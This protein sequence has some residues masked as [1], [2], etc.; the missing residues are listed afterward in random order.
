M[1]IFKVMVALLFVLSTVVQTF[2]LTVKVDAPQVSGNQSGANAAA[3]VLENKIGDLIKNVNDKPKK[4]AKANAN[5]ASYANHVATQRGYTDYEY[6]AFTLGGMAGFQ[7]PSSSFSDIRGLGDN[8]REKGDVEVGASAQFALQLGLRAWPISD[9]LYLGAKIGM[10]KFKLE[11]NDKNDFKYNTFMIGLTGNYL[12]LDNTSIGFG[13]VRW[14]GV[15]FGTGLIYQV[16]DTKYTMGLDSVSSGGPIDL[17]V[18]PRLKYSMDSKNI[19]IPLELTTALRLLYCINLTVGIGADFAFGKTDVKLGME[20]DIGVTGD[21]VTKPGRLQVEGGT[22][23]NPGV[24]KPKF[25]GGIGIGVSDVIIIDVPF[26]LYV[27]S[28]FD[29]GITLGTVW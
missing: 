7:L 5:S 29:V 25:M 18:D 12:L 24:I 28:G 9:N 13:F 23:A 10:M 1:K 3:G 14:R 16:S 11:P 4:F 2:A 8:L 26:T 19:T 21:T 17:S 20:G 27:G 22:G 6:F 15:N